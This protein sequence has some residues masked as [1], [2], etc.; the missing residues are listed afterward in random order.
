MPR[1]DV[2][3][4]L[5]REDSNNWETGTRGSANECRAKKKE[6]AL[7]AGVITPT[8]FT[9]KKHLFSYIRCTVALIP[10][11]MQLTLTCNARQTSEINV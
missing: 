7:L 4:I 10:T 9:Q 8:A 5:L 6:G 2:H 11:C 3:W 1:H